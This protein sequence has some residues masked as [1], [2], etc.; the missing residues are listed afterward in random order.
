M[1]AVLLR[2]G[3]LWV[4]SKPV[5]SNRNFQLNYLFILTEAQLLGIGFQYSPTA[6]EMKLVHLQNKSGAGRLKCCCPAGDGGG[7]GCG[8][9]G[10]GEAA[11]LTAS[12][13]H[14]TEMFV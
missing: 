3:G 6:Q 2:T 4:Y 14:G 1:V 9:G 7:G 13:D 5:Y 12:I 11:A 8:S 10:G